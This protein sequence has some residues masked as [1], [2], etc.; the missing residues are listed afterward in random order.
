LYHFLA[1]FGLI[2]E[3]Q[4]IWHAVNKLWLLQKRF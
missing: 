1:F 3:P 2:P 4:F